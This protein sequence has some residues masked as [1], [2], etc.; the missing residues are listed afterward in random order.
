[1]I[2]IQSVF[3]GF[4]VKNI[5]EAKQFYG[6]I[7]GFQFEDQVGGTSMLLPS[8]NRAWMYQK[9][10]HEPAT[11]TML[12][13][14]VDDIDE[15]YTELTTKGVVFEKYPGSPQDDKGIMRGKS[16]NMGPNIAWFKDPSGNI[17]AIVEL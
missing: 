5:D 13:L 17:L 12:D 10:D 4:S 14:V 16:H 15:A 1:M 9:K 2:K 8:G 3:S 11:Y 6:D 7:L